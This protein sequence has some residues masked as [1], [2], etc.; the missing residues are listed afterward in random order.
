MRNGG[1]APGNRETTT[2]AA[3]SPFVIRRAVYSS[4][5]A[6][7]DGRTNRTGLLRTVGTGAR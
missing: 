5:R 3:R 1:D 4:C 7:A 6:Q 2:S